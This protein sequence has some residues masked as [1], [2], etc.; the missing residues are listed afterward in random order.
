MSQENEREERTAWWGT[1]ENEDCLTSMVIYKHP[2]AD[3]DLPEQD[4]WENS[5]FFVNCPVCGS[6]MMWGGTDHPAD[7]LKQYP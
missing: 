3:Q 7:L 4:E 2:D 6:N 1:C 5:L